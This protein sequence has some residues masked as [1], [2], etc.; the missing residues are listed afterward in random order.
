LP[1]PAPA[2]DLQWISREGFQNTWDGVDA[3]SF[4]ADRNDAPDW[5]K[6]S[7]C[8]PGR[9]SF[10]NHATSLATLAVRRWP[11]QELWNWTRR[12]RVEH[13]F[14]RV[15][16]FELSLA[17][18]HPRHLN[19]I[20]QWTRISAIPRLGNL[21]PTHMLSRAAWSYTLLGRSS[22]SAAEATTAARITASAERECVA[23][24]RLDRSSWPQIRNH[25]KFYR[26]AALGGLGPRSEPAL[27]PG[28]YRIQHA[29]HSAQPYRRLVAT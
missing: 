26:G 7:S 22:L 8:W 10:P 27:L 6:T 15:R 11:T 25:R 1:A 17:G 16:G 3:A 21:P 2:A 19:A 13:R 20:F 14:N 18:W 23:G 12:F 28:I 4:A 24:W 9:A 29:R 5:A